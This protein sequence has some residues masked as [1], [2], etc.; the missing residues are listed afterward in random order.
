MPAKKKSYSSKSK[1]PPTPA[2]MRSGLKSKVKTLNKYL[3]EM[4]DAKVDANLRL[5]SGADKVIRYKLHVD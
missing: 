4:A 3:E 5:T 2:Q 1:K